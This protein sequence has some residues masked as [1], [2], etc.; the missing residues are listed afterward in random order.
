MDVGYAEGPIS[1]GS[2]LIKEK[3][4]AKEMEAKEWAAKEIRKEKV[5]SGKGKA[6]EWRCRGV[7]APWRKRKR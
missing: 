1:N 7:C 5:G 2:A 3:G 6:R 4:R